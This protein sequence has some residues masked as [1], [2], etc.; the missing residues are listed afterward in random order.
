[1]RESRRNYLI[2]WIRDGEVARDTLSPGS[3]ALRRNAIHYFLVEVFGAPEK[4][5][6]KTP[7]FHE[8]ISLPRVI[9]GMLDIPANSKE[10]AIAAMEA[11]S[12]A[13]QAKKDYDPSAAIKAGRGTK[14]LIEGYTAQ[15]ELM[16]RVGEV[17]AAAR[18][19]RRAPA[20][21]Q[22]V[23]AEA[24]QGGARVVHGYRGEGP[25]RGLF[26]VTEVKVPAG[27]SDDEAGGGRGERRR[28]GPGVS[29]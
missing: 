7:N 5:D 12:D 18:E 28:G 1:M 8:R 29:L 26:M 24:Q 13:H 3:A 16:C 6:W 14:A 27:G 17:R 4:E 19:G 9:M 21:E 25:A 2:T 11:I 20:Q 10:A 23:D 15:A 22:E